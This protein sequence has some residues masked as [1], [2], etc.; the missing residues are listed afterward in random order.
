MCIGETLVC[1]EESDLITVV[2]VKSGETLVEIE[3]P[4]VVSA[5]IHPDTYYNKVGHILYL[6]HYVVFRSFWAQPMDVSELLTPILLSSYMNF[7]RIIFLIAK[8]LALS[9]LRLKMCLRSA[10]VTEIFICGI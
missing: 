1:I 3:T 9:S 10:W 7:S 4:F 6:Q 8:L 2:D 5:A